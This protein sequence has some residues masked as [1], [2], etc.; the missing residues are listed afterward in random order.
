MR[1]V[2]GSSPGGR[3]GLF[4]GLLGGLLGWVRRR[5]LRGGLLEGC[6]LMRGLGIGGCC[7]VLGDRGRRVGLLL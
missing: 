5:G 1:P 6:P 2:G 4:L 3:S 7:G